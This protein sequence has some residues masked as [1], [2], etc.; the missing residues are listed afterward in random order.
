MVNERIIEGTVGVFLLLAATALITLAFKVSGLTTFWAANSYQIQARFENV[1]D[2]KVRAPVAMAGVRIGEVSGI[3]LDSLTYDAIVT[4]RIDNEFDQLPADARASIFTAGL[5]GSNYISIAPG[6]E[7]ELGFDDVGVLR[8]GDIIRDTSKALI[9][10]ELIGQFL[11]RF[12]G[13]NDSGSNAESPSV[14]EE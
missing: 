1:G 13:D 5:V 9:L 7:S 6:F 11:F 2:L 8:D 12:G 3:T 4:L 10:Q 14:S